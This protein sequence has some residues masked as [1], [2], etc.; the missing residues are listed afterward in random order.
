MAT[1]MLSGA[2]HRGWSDA[3]MLEVAQ[4]KAIIDG[5][6]DKCSKDVMSTDARK[7][8]TKKCSWGPWMEAGQDLIDHVH[9]Q[10]SDAVICLQL[11]QILDTKMEG[12]R[13][14]DIA[15]SRELHENIRKGVPSGVDFLRHLTQH[16]YIAWASSDSDTLQMTVGTFQEFA[17]K[18]DKLL[19][20]TLI[21]PFDAPPSGDQFED[22]ADLFQHP[23]LGDKWSSIIDDRK[24]LRQPGSHT[25]TGQYGPITA[26]KSFLCVTLS[27]KPSLSSWNRDQVIHWKSSLASLEVGH[28]IILDIHTKD[29]LAVQQILSKANHRLPLSWERPTPSL[30][31]TKKA[32]RSTLRGFL[33]QDNTSDFEARLS[34]KELSKVLQAFQCAIGL[35]ATYLDRSA[36]L[37]EMTDWEA[38][39]SVEHLC[40]DILPISPK[41]ALIHTGVL[42]STWDNILTDTMKN[43]PSQCILRIKWRR[44]Y[45][46]GRPWAQPAVTSA[47]MQAVKTH[48]NIKRQGRALGSG[49]DL[50]STISIPKSLGPAPVALVEELM[51]NIGIEFGAVLNQKQE[52]AT[53]EPG[54][55]CM[56][57]HPGT[58]DPTGRM[59]IRL[60]N[61]DDVKKLEDMFHAQPVEVGGEFCALQVSNSAFMK[62]PLQQGNDMGAQ[63]RVVPPTGR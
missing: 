3:D 21:L 39:Q 36:L 37:V 62:L 22:I 55:W 32:L 41:V 63:V 9:L 54:D 8:K 25:F 34:C 15:K 23:L 6:R 27:T 18:T 53:L 47:Q 13:F 61:S 5:A 4:C 35:R 19:K 31:S 43:N 44:S 59:R 14:L 58:Q 1:F 40:E 20:I 10:Y 45:H 30:A 50:E 16:H 26:M 28:A 29:L 17:S 60:S 52:D 33:P 12:K 46:G 7:R 51:K 48:A 11:S 49:K 38:L 56:L 2:E 24:I 57:K 42:S